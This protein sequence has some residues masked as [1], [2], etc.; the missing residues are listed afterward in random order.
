[1]LRDL[2]S[3]QLLK[4]C[5]RHVN[6]D[7][8]MEFTRRFHPVIAG[9]V[10]RIARL[11][12]ES[13]P[14]TVEDIV[15][16]VYLKL[17]ERG[18]RVLREFREEREDAL[19][20]FLKVVSANVARDWFEAATAIKRGSGQVASLAPEVAIETENEFENRLSRQLFLQKVEA[21]LAR[22]REGA[23]AVRVQSIF[24]LYYRQGF[25]AQEISAIPSLGLSPKGVE[26]LLQRLV[27]QVR[28]K[29]AEGSGAAKPF[30]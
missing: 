16:E 6:E 25:T 21:I 3:G 26:S 12:G 18:C 27:R 17:C 7:A 14:Q 28:S 19:Y 13:N 22:L 30:L 20:A 4:L 23:E 11:R 2:S 10:A 24:W 15:Q 5:V 1:M 8:W 29:L 9:S